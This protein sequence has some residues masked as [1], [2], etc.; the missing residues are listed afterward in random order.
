MQ[1]LL[2]VSSGHKYLD[3]SLHSGLD[4]LELAK[5]TIS[6]PRLFS[7][8]VTSKMKGKTNQR[9]CWPKERKNTTK[10]FVTQKAIGKYLVKRRIP[11]INTI[12]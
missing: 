11:C 9:L 5:L 12:L 7:A 4:T 3:V 8:P 10:M 1:K 6:L 2:D